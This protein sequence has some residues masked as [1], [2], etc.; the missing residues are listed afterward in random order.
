MIKLNNVSFAYEKNKMILRNIHLAIEAGT[1]T[2]L[3]G[4]NGGGKTTIGKL[5]A[6]ILK[7]SVGDVM[8]NELDTRTAELAEIGKKIGYLFQDPQRQLFAPTVREEIAFVMELQGVPSDQIDIRVERYLDKFQLKALENS[9]PF[10]LSRGEKQRLAI[11]AIMVNNPVFYILDEP[12]TGLDYER[13]KVLSAV[14]ERLREE[15]IGMV[16]ISHDQAFVK[17]HAQRVI[18]VSGGELLDDTS[19]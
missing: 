2:V 3:V 18:T 8:V 11:A 15:G 12:T 16:I 4:P 13:K 1:C 14:I 6:G 5:M 17:R 7:P 9:F 10:Q 19:N